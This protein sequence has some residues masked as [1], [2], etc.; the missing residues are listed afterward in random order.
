MVFTAD[1]QFCVA[2][3]L[4]QM[5]SDRP[6][7]TIKP[8]FTQTPRAR[9]K[10]QETGKITPCHSGSP[11]THLL[12]L[13]LISAK[14]R[15]KRLS[16]GRRDIRSGIRNADVGYRKNESRAKEVTLKGDLL[17]GVICCLRARCVI[18]I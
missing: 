11:P 13:A 18:S 12:P 16:N 3:P 17:D 8:H 10:E 7:T 14:R 5:P 15:I 4:P 6:R 2:P 1:L 9:E